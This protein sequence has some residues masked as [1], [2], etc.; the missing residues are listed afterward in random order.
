[1]D[2]QTTTIYIEALG[3]C[4]L[5]ITGLFFANINNW[6]PKI[7]N[8][9]AKVYIIFILSSVWDIVWYHLDGKEEYKFINNI[10]N[11]I[12]LFLLCYVGAYWCDYV[13]SGIPEGLKPKSISKF[14]IFGPPVFVSI[15][16]LISIK[17]GWIYYIDSASFRY[18]RGDCYFVQPLVSY[19]YMLLASLISL[20]VALKTTDQKVKRTHLYKAIFVLPCFVASLF[21]SLLPT[22]FSTTYFG[23]LISMFIIYKIETIDKT[24]KKVTND[25]KMDTVTSALAKNFEFVSY[26]DVHDNTINVYRCSGIFKN[27]FNKNS[28]EN[29][30]NI[31]TNQFDTVL[32]S[33]VPKNK[34]DNFLEQVNRE[35][36]MSLLSAGV[37]PTVDTVLLNE[38]TP[39]WYRIMFALDKKSENVIIGFKCIDKEIKSQ[40]I[41]AAMAEDYESVDYVTV[42]ASNYSDTITVYRSGSIFSEL[43]PNWKEIVNFHNRLE[44]IQTLVCDEDKE[45]FYNETRRPRIIKELK[46]EGNYYINFKIK[47]HDKKSYYQLHFYGDRNEDDE[48]IGYVVGV[49]NVDKS[50]QKQIEQ[51]DILEKALEMAHAANQAKTAFL[52]NMSHDIRTP[53]NAIIGF[54]DLAKKHIDNSEQVEGYLGKITSSSEHLLSLINDVLDMSRIE[55]GKMS[56]NEN[57]ESISEIMQ[58]LIDI[59]QADVNKKNLSLITNINDIKNDNVLCDKLRLKQ[60]LL[61]IISNA[62]KYTEA[63]GTVTISAKQLDTS[64]FGY[65][66]YEFRVK[67]TGMGMSP[68]YVKTIFEPF[69]REKTVG[70]IQG[71]GLG[72]AITKNFV[73]MMG[74]N[75]EV[76][77][78]KGVGSEFI[79]TLDFEI[80]DAAVT[81][82]KKEEKEF[83]FDGKRVLLVDDNEMNREIGE[84]I[85]SENG[86]IVETADDGTTAVEAV[87]KVK[88]D[89]FDA[90]LMD[91]QMPVMDGYTATAEIRKL[92]GF[93]N[94]PIIAMTANAFAEDRQAALDAGM[95]EHLAKPINIAALNSALAKF[96]K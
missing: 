12:Y 24:E 94:I 45:S 73:D 15:I 83:N 82:D 16:D 31:T 17:T 81:S 1:M 74:G 40:H 9:Y 28:V 4:T 54:T 27:K 80:T 55:S 38:E 68:E 69:T 19:L 77:S 76:K 75:I 41:I 62:V 72:M 63:G 90:I 91:V 51:A 60:I 48:I 44:L 21:Q 95:N 5:L 18:T 7:F 64:N 29:L 46:K 20:Y 79:V 36:I 59:I 70:S 78:E 67:D 89:Y 13:C 26:I 84:E 85:L 34:F 42:T 3:M 92:P 8:S 25:L 65:G 58:M 47:V 23:T 37:M 88:P 86:I 53:M 11:G 35:K 56:L 52:N 39:K 6:R 43:I 50:M 49:R 71:T 57:K 30:N 2:V 22:G 32:Q 87:K 61:N 66:K 14:L 33:L 96:I 10:G 93:A